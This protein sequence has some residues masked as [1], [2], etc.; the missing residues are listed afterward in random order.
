MI[1]AGV[2]RE[3]DSNISESQVFKIKTTSQA[4]K[5]LS[6]NLYS[7]KIRAIVRELS[8]NAVDSHKMAQNPNPFEVH[9]PSIFEPYFSVRDFG[10]GLSDYDVFN[11]YNSYFESTKS[12]SNDFIGALG[13]GSKS[14]FSYV[15]SFTVESVFN[16]E[17]R[18][19]STYLNSAGI[20]TTSLMSSIECSDH[21]GLEVKIPI[22]ESDF[23]RFRREA[24]IVFYAFDIKPTIV[25]SP[26][27]NDLQKVEETDNC[28]I[29][30]GN[31]WKIVN[32]FPGAIIND[33]YARQ[34]SIIYP[35]NK[36]ILQ[37]GI[38]GNERSKIDFILY[39]K[40]VVNFPLGQ[41]DVAAS[42]EELSYDETTKSNILKRI[43]EVYDEIVGEINKELDT[44]SLYDAINYVKFSINK[45]RNAGSL[46][47][48]HSASGCAITGDEKFS[49]AKPLTYYTLIKKFGYGSLFDYKVSTRRNEKSSCSDSWSLVV[50]PDKKTVIFIE[51]DE[52]LSENKLKNKLRQY[53]GVNNYKDN[54]TI[55]PFLPEIKDEILETFG[56]PAY[57]K[58]SDVE[59]PII[60]KRVAMERSTEKNFSTKNEVSTFSTLDFYHV[61][62][63]SD[64]IK[65]YIPTYIDKY[66][67]TID[68][69]RQTEVGGYFLTKY[70]K[71]LT[72]TGFITNDTEFYCVKKK[73]LKYKRF[74]SDS[75]FELFDE[76]VEEHLLKYIDKNERRIVRLL[77]R[78]KEIDNIKTVELV[79]CSFKD[80]KR[81][82]ENFFDKLEDNA[83]KKAYLKL[84]NKKLQKNIE[85]MEGLF[86]SPCIPKSVKQKI[87]SLE[88]SN[89]HCFDIKDVMF[90][91]MFEYRSWKS[92]FPA[93]LECLANLV[94]I[95]Y[96]EKSRNATV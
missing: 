29:K 75:N 62:E 61:S 21:N 79:S 10:I 68:K 50:Y 90:L 8:C 46:K 36:D 59:L 39:N 76:A 78:K 91:N 15:D 72:S 7:N 49:Y 85:Q 19:Y 30:S 74:L 27:Y 82:I 18:I 20:P 44:L 89:Q 64:S 95:I 86:N 35:L 34:G 94:N 80:D 6:S 2:E 26:Q 1:L 4:F 16:G 17:K 5:I 71:L 83:F 93:E 31:G 48:I 33:A 42:R 45:V 96:R 92:D 69:D 37:E 88:L 43:Y 11:L 58:L 3:V 13:L 66:L 9:L 55:I 67:I 70:I 12:Q 57:I 23:D 53:A 24:E 73:E 47:L 52:Q 63:S 40:I 22:K 56:N 54:I 28:I 81:V 60:E 32:T 77:E 65:Y 51:M 87:A 41:L 38:E 84:S 14:P 25:N